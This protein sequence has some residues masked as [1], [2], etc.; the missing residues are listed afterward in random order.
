MTKT[1]AQHDDERAERLAG[2]FH[3]GFVALYLI[4]AFWHLRGAQPHFKRNAGETS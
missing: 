3:L 1:H 2:W 4:A